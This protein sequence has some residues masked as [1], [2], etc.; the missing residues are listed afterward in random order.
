MAERLAAPVACSSCKTANREGARFCVGCGKQLPDMPKTCPACETANKSDAQ[1]C[2]ECGL[3]L[4]GNEKVCPSCGARNNDKAKFCRDCATPLEFEPRAYAVHEEA[5]H[6]TANEHSADNAS[7]AASVA[8]ASDTLDN[9]NSAATA[10]ETAGTLR[11]RAQLIGLIVQRWSRDG[12]QLAKDR[13][14]VAIGVAVVLAALL[15][16]VPLAITW[17]EKKGS[18][19]PTNG[20]SETAQGSGTLYAT[21]F[22]HIRNGPTSIGTVVLGDLQTG[23]AVSGTWVLGHD[24]VTRWL[25]IQQADGSYGFV[26]GNNLSTASQPQSS[27]DSSAQTVSTDTFNQICPRALANAQGINFVP[28]VAKL[29]TLNAQPVSTDH[30]LCMAEGRGITYSIT[31]KIRCNDFSQVRCAPVMKVMRDDGRVLWQALE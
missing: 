13:P 27:A 2:R 22:T 25:R 15:V 20:I 30:Y 11:R 23:Q 31:V 9:L 17:G 18:S 26:W 3:A 12:R 6:E 7:E 19:V 5:G 29:V 1:F 8:N 28:Y 24:G 16:G 4:G 21:R 14:Y 10:A